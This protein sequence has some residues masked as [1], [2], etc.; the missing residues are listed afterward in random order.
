ML[1]KSNFSIKP[2][3]LL[4][5]C[6]GAVG[7]TSREWGVFA[8]PDGHHARTLIDHLVPRLAAVIQDIVAGSEHT[9]RKPVIAHEPPNILDRVE[10]TT[11]G[12]ERDDT[13]FSGNIQLIS[14]MLTGWPHQHSSVSAGKTR[15]CPTMPATL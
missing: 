10:F 9:V 12:W 6:D 14:H 15:L 5:K 1:L 2:I 13:D 7:S 4:H 8:V 3:L 11:F